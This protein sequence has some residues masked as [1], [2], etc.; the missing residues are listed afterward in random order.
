M[1]MSTLQVSSINRP[2]T[3]NVLKAP[4]SFT[5]PSTSIQ[6]LTPSLQISSI[7]I[8]Y[9]TII[10]PHLSFLCPE[11]ILYVTFCTT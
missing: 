10:Y 1:Y 4:S 11:N 6:V 8:Y 5:L 2:H 3:H 9:Q 7:S